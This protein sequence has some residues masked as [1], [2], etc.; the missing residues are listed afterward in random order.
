M[1]QEKFWTLLSKK[2]SAEA[3]ADELKELESL[4]RQHPEWQ[5]A[6]QNL[7]DLWKHESPNDDQH[8]EDAYMLHLHRMQELGIPFEE[9]QGI[10]PD[11][12]PRRRWLN[13][14]KIAIAAVFLAGGFFLFTKIISGNGKKAVLAQ[15]NEIST[16][17]GS[18]S[19]VQ[20]PDSSVVWLNAGSKLTYDKSFGAQTR[21]VQLTGEG[22]FD[23]VKMPGKPFIIQ[24]SS[25][26]I[27]VLG[28]VF[29]V[30]AYPEDKQTV[31]SL[32][33][34][35]IEVTIVNRPDNKIILSP[36]EKLVV[37]NKLL[38]ADK[39]S[40]NDLPPAIF[41][42]KLK[43]DPV[44][45][46]IAETLWVENKLA[47]ND[48]SFAE[49][50]KS[51]ERWYN[52]KIEITDAELLNERLTGSFEKESVDQALEAL[53]ITIPFRFEKNGNNISIYR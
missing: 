22:Y 49:L 19:K 14:Y 24:T 5:Y 33:R 7:Q 6:I 34:G 52:V 21:T 50:V 32:I 42:N 23:V 39:S 31:T 12:L 35:S 27:K 44:D 47:F 8:S 20:L 17:P 2:L 37:E 46:S 53:R 13:R 29:N 26:N 45:S 30:K 3:S 40:V 38:T 51:M 9:E 4:I 15:V 41:V 28:T 36:K 18:T 1:S 48:E 11:A 43:Y 10:A 25:I 16:R